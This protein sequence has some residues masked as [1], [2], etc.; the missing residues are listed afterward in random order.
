MTLYLTKADVLAIAEEILPTVGLRDGGQ[1]HAAVLR[2][3]T[4][5]FGEDAYLDLWTKAAALLQSLLIGDPLV[6]GNKRLAWTSAVVFLDLNGE[7]LSGTDADAAEAL[8]ISVT[9]GELKDTAD[10]AERLRALEG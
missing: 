6:D 4:T 3:Q 10:I 9:T 8:V 5:V 7:T 1:L 2:P